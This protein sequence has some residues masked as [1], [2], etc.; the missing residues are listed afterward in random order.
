MLMQSWRDFIELFPHV[1]N[2]T[3]AAFG[4]LRAVGGFLV[5]A[6]RGQDGVVAE[7]VTLTSTVGGTAAVLPPWPGHALAVRRECADKQ[8]VLL[9]WC[10]ASA[11]SCAFVPA[12][13]P[14]NRL[15]PH[16]TPVAASHP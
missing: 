11:S 15:L 9:Q 1:P 12:D 5:S 16:T 6:Q 10:R 2:G 4:T 14:A 8:A 7:P 13:T 3:A